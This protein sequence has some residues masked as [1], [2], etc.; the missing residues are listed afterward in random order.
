MKRKLLSIMLAGAMLVTLL[1]GCGNGEETATSVP[2]TTQEDTIGETAPAEA[3][4]PASSS[5]ETIELT[6][7]DASWNEG[8]TEKLLEKFHEENPNIRVKVEFFPD[9]GMSDR[10]L[11]AIMAGDGADLLSVNNEWISTYAA[12]G[13]LLNLDESIANNNIDMTEFFPGVIDGITTQGSVYGMPYRAETH[14]IYYNED[15]FEAAGADAMPETWEE[16]LPILQGATTGDVSGIAIPGGQMGNTSYQL[17]NLIMSNGGS[18]LTEDNSAS[19]LDSQEVIDAAKFFVE[20]HTVH[21][22][23]P[24]SI[25][26]NDN[27]AGR[28][29]FE[30]ENTASFMSG[31]FDIDTIREA[32]PEMN[33]NTAML[34]YFE[35]KDRKVILAGWSTAVASHTKHPEEAFKVAEF[36]ASPE[37]S[38]E[39]STTFSAREAMMSNEKYAA[40]PLRKNLSEMLPYGAVLPVIPQLT[41][42]RQIMFEEIQL[43]LAGDITAEQ[44]MLNAHEKVDAIL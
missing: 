26:E 8:V 6:M 21:G 33:F 44:A 29:L 38:V 1:A 5:G 36:L 34:P 27:A 9:N 15:M 28:S 3:E 11:T 39:Y 25:L 10:Y 32:N 37:I 18:I 16:L 31:P 43:A 24:P 2:E 19:N 22:V 42:I 13:G 14:G 7:W 20:L 41:Q 17:I 35:G 30:G 40:D 12:A 4:A 23:T